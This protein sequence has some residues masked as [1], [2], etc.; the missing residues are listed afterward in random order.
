MVDMIANRMGFA[1][2]V[3]HFRFHWHGAPRSTCINQGRLAAC[4][5]LC[6]SFGTHAAAKH[7]SGSK[8]FGFLVRESGRPERFGLGYVLSSTY[9]SAVLNSSTVT[10]FLAARTPSSVII[11]PGMLA[12]R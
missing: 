8:P 9:S 4:V 1:G 7:A 6:M 2:I 5:L 3:W 11:Q 12:P 10:K